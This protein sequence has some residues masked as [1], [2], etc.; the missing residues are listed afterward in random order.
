MG[1]VHQLPSI[2]KELFIDEDDTALR[3]SW[4]LDQGLVNFSVWRGDTCTETFPL[5]VDDASRLVAFLVDGLATAARSGS[6]PP[7]DAGPTASVLDE[8]RSTPGA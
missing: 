3:A 7:A 6:G 1:E 2:G 8:L 4:H 5:S